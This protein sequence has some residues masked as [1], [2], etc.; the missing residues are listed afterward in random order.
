MTDSRDRIALDLETIPL[1]DNP[2][3]ETPAHWTV[4]AAAL[5]HSD[6]DA[7]E[8]D[9]LFRDS[10]T[11]TSEAALI[12]DAIDWIAERAGS[13]RVILTYNGENYDLPVLKH[14]AERIDAAETGS[15][16]SERLS[17]LLDTS[18]HVD[19]IED[20][21]DMTGDWVSL[22]DALESHDITADTPMWMGEKVAGADMP[23]MGLELLTER[24]NTD[25]REA[26]RR[27]AASDVEPLFELHES[28]QGRAGRY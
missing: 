19:L 28:L 22:D 25:L 3:F 14:R 4:F 18:Q 17:L 12:N 1:V 5:G 26:V 11:Y 2:D 7:T 10:H 15:N 20:M 9:V 8:V 27:Y 13:N 6:G 24:D 21:R 23:S 16:V